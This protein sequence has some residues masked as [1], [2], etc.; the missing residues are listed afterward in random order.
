MAGLGGGFLGEGVGVVL[1]HGLAVG[2]ED[3][4]LLRLLLELPHGTKEG[5]DPGDHQQQHQQA[6]H[7]I[8]HEGDGLDVHQGGAAPLGDDPRGVDEAGVIDRPGG[9]GDEHH[10]RGGGGT[11]DVGRHGPV[12]AVGVVE[13]L[14]DGT[15]GQDV[16][17]VIHEEDHAEGPLRQQGA[18]LGGG[19]PGEHPGEAHGGPGFLQNPHQAAQQAHHQQH[20]DVVRGDGLDLLDEGVEPIPLIPQDQGQEGGDQ[21]GL[22]GAFGDQGHDDE[23]DDRDDADDSIGCWFH[24]ITPFLLTGAGRRRGWCRG[25]WNDGSFRVRS[26]RTG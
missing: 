22:K 4:G 8:E 6:E 11:D 19:K 25:L 12:D 20:P 1:A 13:A 15:G 16:Q 24:V 3:A 21:Q 23:D 14:G 26:W 18:L 7:G 5:D 2:E 10:H 17:V 9:Q